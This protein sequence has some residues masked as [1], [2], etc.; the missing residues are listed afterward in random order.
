MSIVITGASGQLGR[1]VAEKLIDRVDPSDLVL[2]TRTPESL[3]DFADKGAVVR[4]GD[5]DDPSTLSAAFAGGDRLLLISTDSIGARLAG[6]KA[7]IEAATNAG[8]GFVA[9]TSVIKPEPPNPARVAPDHFAT[10][11]AL[12]QSDLAWSFLRNS[13]YAHMQLDA[14]QAALAT[15]KLFTNAGD[16]R[17]SY[18]TRED[19]AAAAAAVLAG[20]DHDN[21]I[22]DITGP[23]ALDAAALSALFAEFGAGAVEPVYLDDATYAAGLVQ[24]GLPEPVA[25][26]L[27]SF[28][29]A[30]RD[31]YADVVSDSVLE[32]TGRPP[33][34]LRAV[35]ESG[36][37]PAN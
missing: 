22:Y 13:V 14:A 5:F 11:Q 27:A 4:H 25:E 6:H 19:C 35:L 37:R 31:G 23:E 10:E 30:A 3:A 8:V 16:G 26:L 1:K 18:V 34:A 32:L 17:T 36:L 7:A 33:T 21:T 2:V 29:A 20:G 9:Y 24:S 15:G 28:G 12:R